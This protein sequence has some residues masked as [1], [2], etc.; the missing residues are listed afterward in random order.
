VGEELAEDMADPQ[1]IT[2]IE[3]ADIA[4][5]EL[6]ADRLKITITATGAESRDLTLTSGGPASTR[7]VSALKEQTA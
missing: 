3:W 7:L 5:D 1:Y 6:P 4:Q 2:I